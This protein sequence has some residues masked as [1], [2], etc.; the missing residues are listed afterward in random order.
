VEPNDQ[1]TKVAIL[2]G[3]SRGLGMVLAQ[4]LLKCGW[5]VATFSRSATPFTEETSKSDPLFTFQAIDATNHD[6]VKKFVDDL[7][8]KHGRIDALINNAAV[9]YDGTLATFPEERIE[10]VIDINLTS[11][12]ILT[13][14]CVR[15]MLLRSSG[16]IINISSI[17]GL[18]GY[19]GLAAYSA[20][21]AGL[22][23]ITRSLARELGQRNITVNAIAPGYLETEMSH[24]LDANQKTQIIRRTPLGRLGTSEDVAGVVEFLLSDAA[25]FITGET[26]T[27]DGGITC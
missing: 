9:A 12:L 21:K 27:V 7:Y 19:S 6:A 17:I 18:R 4:R 11:V 13:K 1:Q 23:G 26:I 14:A 5:R 2:S 20:S 25:S 15:S 10:K 24:G 22:L 8:D 16:R 3:G